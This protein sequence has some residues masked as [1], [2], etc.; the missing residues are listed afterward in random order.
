MELLTGYDKY[1]PEII[2]NCLIV[3]DGIEKDIYSKRKF[4]KEKALTNYTVGNDNEIQN[5]LK[6]KNNK[7]HSDVNSNEFLSE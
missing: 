6:E 5:K 2:D 3:N 4:K 7:T 1:I